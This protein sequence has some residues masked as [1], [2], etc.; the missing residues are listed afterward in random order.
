MEITKMTKRL[1]FAL[2]A[3]AIVASACSDDDADTTTQPA[4]SEPEVALD[5][6]TGPASVSAEDQTGDGTSVTVASV[7]LPGDGFVVIHADNGGAPGPV[8]GH[9]A[10]LGAGESTDVV[11]TLDTP[12]DADATVF[13][14]AHIDA[15]ANGE[16]EF[17]P[18]DVTTDVPATTDD[19]AVAVT[20]IGY[21]IG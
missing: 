7:T 19:G 10:L 2:V 15:N 21:T 6:A 16:Y 13:P 5:M 20:G 11:V 14:M 18:P 9:S 8:I 3:L 12:L 17:A 4:D 1:L